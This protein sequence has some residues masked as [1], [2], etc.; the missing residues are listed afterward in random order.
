MLQKKTLLQKKSE[1]VFSNKKSVKSNFELRK[2]VNTGGHGKNEAR[3]SSS[4]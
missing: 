4:C 3:L 2:E 1:K